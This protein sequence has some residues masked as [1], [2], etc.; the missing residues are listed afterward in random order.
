MR[1]SEAKD[2]GPD[3]GSPAGASA[4]LDEVLLTADLP[5]VAAVLHSRWAD[6]YGGGVAPSVPFPSVPVKTNDCIKGQ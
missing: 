5:D 4:L 2:V 3:Y 6:F 1:F